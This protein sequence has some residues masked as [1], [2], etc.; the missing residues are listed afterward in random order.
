MEELIVNF[1]NQLAYSL[2]VRSNKKLDTSNIRNIIILGMG[3]SG[4]GGQLVAQ[5]LQYHVNIPILTVNNYKLPAFVN[6]NSWVIA[7]SYSGNTEETLAAFLEASNRNAQLSV[8]SS[9]GRLL[10]YANEKGITHVAL[11][12]G[13]PAPRACLGFS[14]KAQLLL[15]QHA[16]FISNDIINDL[17]SCQDFLNEQQEDIRYRATTI[18]QF[19]HNKT[20]VLY[21]ENDFEAVLIRWVQQ[22]NENA[23]NLAMYHVVPEMN[24]N[25]IVG[26]EKNHQD[27]AVIYLRNKEDHLK[28]Q[29][30][31]DIMK[32]IIRPKAASIIEI[33]AKGNSFLQKALYTIHLGDFLSLEMS[34]LYDVDIMSIDSINH[35]KGELKRLT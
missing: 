8:V 30:R 35:L 20:L 6:E 13:Y 27:K 9:G 4:I 24:H 12:N 31:M 2:D 17:E 5:T 25:E 19:T 26:W 29:L 3:G 16:G 34:K 18:A 28:N 21:A 11:P 10:E 1:P 15:L 23:K 14:L 33:I 32:E 22:I 7:S